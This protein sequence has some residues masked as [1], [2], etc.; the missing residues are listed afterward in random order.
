MGMPTNEMRPR[1][2]SVFLTCV[3]FG[4]EAM[5]FEHHSDAFQRPTQR[6][7][8]YHSPLATVLA[9]QTGMCSVEIAKDVMP[10]TGLT[11]PVT[12]ADFVHTPARYRLGQ[13]EV[14]KIIRLTGC[15]RYNS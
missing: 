14:A 5:F 6:N 8:A 3:S 15:R 1:S 2:G 13:P 4:V 12:F 9:D 10:T 7:P 11:Q